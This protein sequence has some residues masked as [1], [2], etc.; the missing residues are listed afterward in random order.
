MSKRDGEKGT[1]IGTGTETEEARGTKT[2]ESGVRIATGRESETGTPAAES[3]LVQKTSPPS[4]AT[5]PPPRSLPI[6]RRCT[7]TMTT[8]GS[9]NNNTTNTSP[10]IRIPTRKDLMKKPAGARRDGSASPRATSW[11]LR[12]PGTSS[13]TMKRTS[14]EQV[15]KGRELQEGRGMDPK[16]G[17]GGGARGWGI[18][19]RV[20]REVLLLLLLLL[21]V[22]GVLVLARESVGAASGMRTRSLWMEQRM[23][24]G[25]EAGGRGGGDR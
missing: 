17:S 11:P 22:L 18:A 12:P 4:A 14:L 16:M 8:T 15:E 20:A 5:R 21:L 13:W 7:A 6:L 19:L 25:A 9:T 23:G 3:A 10:R 2:Q 1:G 24:A